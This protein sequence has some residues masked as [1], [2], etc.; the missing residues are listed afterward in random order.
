MAAWIAMDDW[1][2]TL[3]VTFERNFHFNAQP[4]TCNYSFSTFT[5]LR[6]TALR[7]RLRTA[8]Q[9]SA[10]TKLSLSANASAGAAPRTARA[11][12]LPLR[13]PLLEGGSSMQSCSRRISDV[14]NTSQITTK[15]V[16]KVKCSSDPSHFLHLPISLSPAQ[17]PWSSDQS[18][19]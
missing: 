15:N 12:T 19:G 18:K 3:T 13:L 2:Q 5:P 6:S 4:K 1:K 9:V 11:P 14:R 16:N 17:S 10:K 7:R 8:A